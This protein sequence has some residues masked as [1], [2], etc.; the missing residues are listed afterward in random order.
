MRERI[1]PCTRGIEAHCASPGVAGFDVPLN[2]LDSARL[3]KVSAW[4]PRLSHEREI[5]ETWNFLA[6][7]R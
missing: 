4:I 2:V 3:G 6:G 7:T 5:E 1:A